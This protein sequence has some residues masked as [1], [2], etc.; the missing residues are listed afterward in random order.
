MSAEEADELSEFF[1]AQNIGMS[2][3][4]VVI[5][6]RSKDHFSRHFGSLKPTILDTGFTPLG[7][8]FRGGDWGQGMWTT[9]HRGSR[10]PCKYRFYSSLGLGRGNLLGNTGARGPGTFSE[11]KSR[12]ER[13]PDPIQGRH[14]V[15]TNGNGSCLPSFS[16]K[17][18]VTTSPF[19]SNFN[20]RVSC[21][22]L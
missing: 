1:E 9:G 4:S 22:R 11:P 8:M 10:G 6:S 18:T 19:Q 14:H 3:L 15:F 20:T 7:L 2:F 17:R 13:G 5:I 21:K 16:S 12:R